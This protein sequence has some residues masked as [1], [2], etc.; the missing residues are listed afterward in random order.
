MTVSFYV[1][2]DERGATEALAELRR[3]ADAL[4][5][6]FFLAWYHFMVGYF[7]AHRGDFPAAHTAFAASAQCCEAVG[8]PSTGGFTQAWWA[9]VRAAQG[10]PAAATDLEALIARANA[11]GSGLAVADAAP[12]LADIM[13]GAGDAATPS[14][15][16][17]PIIEALR[18]EGPPVFTMQCLRAQGAALRLMD[19]LD[20]ADAALDEA[21]T[22]AT[23]L[24]NDWMRAL[25]A[26]EQALVAQRRG[27][28]ERAEN[29]LHAAL[30]RQ[31]RHG[32]RPGIAATMDALGALALD[33]ESTAEAVRCFAAADTLRSTIGVVRSARDA[34]VH[35]RHLTAA[36]AELGD[37]VFDEHW[38]AAAS[39]TLEEMIEYVSRARGERKRPS[40][41]WASLTPTEQRI[42]A[43]VAE[44]LTNPQIAERM[45]IA[46]GTVK[47][48][49]SHVFAKLGVA[50]R[51]ELATQA[52]KQDVARDRE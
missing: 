8:D 13:M 30:D 12:I 38:N 36:R 6:G 10:D 52:T 45:F 39:L 15:L 34:T 16:L 51:A 40:A 1:E 3:V 47:V 41:G 24:A 2:H 27:D 44:G 48:H 33:A 26:Y 37:E 4:E 46:R 35:E 5:S 18:D 11:T 49:L 14:A 28:A 19:D 17:A 29:L 20:G 43:L 25:V 23:A 22:M 31:A 7:A 50:T 32:L 21:E 9:G 42:V